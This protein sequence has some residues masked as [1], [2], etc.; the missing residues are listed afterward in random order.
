MTDEIIK[1][2][3]EIKDALG[4]TEGRDLSAFCKKLNKASEKR[5]THLIRHIR[6]PH[7]A[8]KK[9]EV[10]EESSDYNAGESHE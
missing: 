9:L 2:L 4:Q 1:E 5:G 7:E 10:A 8:T 3:W 6:Y